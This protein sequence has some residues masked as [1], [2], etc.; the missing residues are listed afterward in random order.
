ML[1]SL[2]A[3]AEATERAAQQGTGPAT[4]SA[5]PQQQSGVGDALKDIV[6]AEKAMDNFESRLDALLSRLG[7]LIDD[8]DGSTPQ[9]PEPG[10][11]QS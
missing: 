8:S 3:K 9:Q 2:A 5:G 4:I 11:A 10:A 7:S 1:G 6:F